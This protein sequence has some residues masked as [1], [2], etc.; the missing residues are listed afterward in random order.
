M[1]TS[2]ST[3]ATTYRLNLQKGITNIGSHPANDIVIDDPRVQPFHL[4]LDHRKKPYQIISLSPESNIRLNGV[5]IAGN[6]PIEVKDLNQVQFNGFSLH[7]NLNQAGGEIS[8]IEIEP[9]RFQA[10]ALSPYEVLP[11]IPQEP[12]QEPVTPAQVSW[13]E[14]ASEPRQFPPALRDDIILVT[15]VEVNQQVDVEVPA[16]YRLSV[17]NAGPI[18]ASFDVRVEGVPLEWVSISPRK[19]NLYE[20]G[21]GEC[22]IQ[23]AA[24]RDS[25]STAASYP[26]QFSVSSPNYPD[27]L[28]QANSSFV[29]NP[30]FEYT[31]GNLDPKQRSASYNKRTGMVAFPISNL[32]NSAEVYQVSAADDEN[33]LQFEFPQPDQ[34]RLARQS[35]V[36]VGAGETKNVPMV[37]NPIRRHIFRLRGRQYHYNVH[38]RQIEQESGGQLVS[39]GFTSQP[40]LGFFSLLLI[41]AVA[42]VSVFFLMRPRIIEFYAV[43]DIVEKGQA[44]TL[45]WKVSFFTRDLLIEGIPDPIQGTQSQVSTMPTSVASTYTLVASN[46]LSRLLRMPDLRSET[47]TV[48]TIPAPP[49]ITTF[50]VD[51]NEAFVGDTVKAKWSIGNADLAYLTVDGITTILDPESFNGELPITLA[52]D[53]LVVLEAKNNAGSLVRSE[54]LQARQPSI[55]IEEFS[56]SKTTITLGDPVTIRWKVSGIGAESVMIAPFEEPLP[57]EGELTFYPKESMEFVMSV[58]NRDLSEIR[59][60]PVGVLPPGAPPEPPAISFFKAAPNEMVGE[61]TTEFSWSISGLTDKI[62]ITSSAGLVAGALPAQGFKSTGVKATTNFV[63]T[64]YN[65]EATTSAIVEVKVKPDLMPTQ[66]LINSTIPTTAIMRGDTMQVYFSVVPMVDGKPVLDVIAAKLPEVSGKV[67]VTDGFDTCEAELPKTSCVIQLN[68]SSTDKKLTATYG[69]DANY[70]RR[71]SPPYPGDG[72]LSVI[73]TPADFKLLAFDPTEV[74]LGQLTK[75]SFTLGPTDPTKVDPVTGEVQVFQ[76]IDGQESAIPLCRVNLGGVLNEPN[77]GTGSCSVGFPTTG[78]K[79]LRVKYMGNAVYDGVIEDITLSVTK[80]KSIT[81]ITTNMAVPTVTGQTLQVSVLVKADGGISLTPTGQVYIY[82]Q[83]DNTIGCY[84]TLAESIGS[85]DLVFNQA[86]DRQVVAQYLS[87]T[88]VNFESSLSAPALHPVSQASTKT[89]FTSLPAQTYVGQDIT[90]SFKSEVLPPG[91]G[92]LSGESVVMNGVN[93]FCTGFESCWGTIDS[94]APKAFKVVY[95]PTNTDLNYG[96]SESAPVSYAP[97]PS[98]TKFTLFSASTVPAGGDPTQGTVTTPIEYK[99]RVEAEPYSLVLP[100]GTVTVRA[101]TGEQCQISVPGNDSCQIE[102]W[103]TEGLRSVQATFD[104]NENYTLSQ[105]TTLSYVVKKNSSVTTVT[106]TPSSV[107][108]DRSVTFN[109]SVT[110]QVASGTEIPTGIVMVYAGTQNCIVTLGKEW[111]GITP[112]LNPNEGSCRM[113]FTKAASLA[114]TAQYQGD[115]LFVGSNYNG[116][117][118]NVT[119]NRAQTI[120]E[121][122]GVSTLD[123]LLGQAFTVNFKV[124]KADALTYISDP[125]GTVTVK[126]AANSTVTCTGTVLSDGT[127]SCQLTLI[128]SGSRTLTAVYEETPDVL[129][130]ETSTSA[131][132]VGLEVTNSNTSI[133]VNVTYSNAT[134]SAAVINQP[135]LVSFVVST[136]VASVIPAP[137]TVTISADS[138]DVPSEQCTVESDANDGTGSCTIKFTKIGSRTITVTYPGATGF[139]PSTFTTGPITVSKASVSLTAEDNKTTIHVGEM[140]TYTVGV[141][142]VTPSTGA[143]SGSLTLTAVSGANTATGTCP[144]LTSC[145]I[146]YPNY[147]TWTFTLTFLE[148]DRYLEKQYSETAAVEKDTTATLPILSTANPTVESP[149]NF[150]VRVTAGNSTTVKPTLPDPF[151]FTLDNPNDSELTAEDISCGSLTSG[152]DSTSPY[153]AYLTAI[154]SFTPD[155]KGDW[156]IVTT[157]PGDDNFASSTAAEITIAVGALPTNMS[158]TPSPSPYYVTQSYTF[159]ATIN[160]GT[161][162]APTGNVVFSVTGANTLPPACALVGWTVNSSTKVATAACVIPMDNIGATTVTAAYDGDKKY[163]AAID[164]TLSFSVV[165][166]PTGL[167]ASP[168]PLPTSVNQEGSLSFTFNVTATATT[169][170]VE[171]G[172]VNLASSPSD[173]FAPMPPCTVVDGACTVTA[174]IS[175]TAAPGNYTVSASYPGTTIFGSS[176]SASLGTLTVRYPTTLTANPNPFPASINQ[177]GSLSLPFSVTAMGTTVGAGTVSVESNPA[178]LFATTPTCTV[179]SGA[180][181]ATLTIPSGATPGDYTITATYAETTAYESS[182]SG[183]LGTLTVRYPTTLS[184]TA[185]P[186]PISVNQGE[187]DAISFDFSVTATG[188]TVNAGTV[189]IQATQVDAPNGTLFTTPPSC[190][191]ASAN[192]CNRKITIPSGATPGAYTVTATYTGTTIFASSASITLGTLTVRNPTTTTLTSGYELPASIFQGSS[193]LLS[194]NVTA[195]DILPDF[196]NEGIVKIQATQVASPNADMFLPADQPSCNISNGTCASSI[197]LTI[198]LTATPGAYTVIATYEETTTFASSTLALGTMIVNELTTP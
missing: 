152:F 111:D 178:G 85:C 188:T 143:L 184:E 162:P 117:A 70:A 179:A 101:S 50:S 11:V 156:K 187:V 63:L 194:F 56:L 138:P 165:L 118:L 95:D 136:P 103:N 174:T 92:T 149:V 113:T 186:L 173:L 25:S 122:T 196:V 106:A 171:G 15:L 42:A 102:T 172:Q 181:T 30:F 176:T 94:V 48:L 19:L 109:V 160:Y 175:A 10:E 29:L 32:G 124:S 49:A 120:T 130:F 144:S 58:A 16:V 96:T 134:I 51:K 2:T 151:E 145:T 21:R 133:A 108:I 150:V 191:I 36:K 4:I 5:T 62:E 14:K 114:V 73:G 54:F 88:D 126:D 27:H 26:L 39:G 127:G 192:P 198:P 141:Q 28:G 97:L 68:T 37:I 74:N 78:I 98:P 137:A 89:V 159:T 115:T 76:V 167:T 72:A 112:A 146:S 164:Q 91:S 38:A 17:I 170:I 105:S 6:D 148:N 83:A 69:G 60:L 154:C 168:N 24:P 55:L 104:A 183:P 157:Y 66:V 87:G 22:E 3:H 119:V 182:T 161:G 75:L 53:T 147:G 23:I 185:D 35:E 44:V 47:V 189:S 65:K 190:D 93:V 158:L 52:R 132:F 67:V 193:S 135:V 107:V 131:A 197:I 33:G 8:E 169:S 81:T 142:A 90:F 80:G 128:N 31:L 57:L 43:K 140:V 155:V 163:A 153:K 61:G 79:T 46:W 1:E 45:R 71:T 129:R 125:T 12:V 139:N 166:I 100:T 13:L 64:A 41:L 195:P 177:A 180:C 7:A 99:V 116:P 40:L 34:T 86:G 9:P 110:S 20:S 18:V 123:P 84:A 121:I 82:D 59:L 77:Q